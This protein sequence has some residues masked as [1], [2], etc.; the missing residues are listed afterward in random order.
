MKFFHNKLRDPS[1]IPCEAD[2]PSLVITDTMNCRKEFEG[3]VDME[4]V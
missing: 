1:N 4:E 2:C 3:L